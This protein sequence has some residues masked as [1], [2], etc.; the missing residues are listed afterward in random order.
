[1]RWT[2]NELLVKV[3]GSKNGDLDEDKFALDGTR[4]GVV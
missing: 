1:M 4:V 3:F 2:T